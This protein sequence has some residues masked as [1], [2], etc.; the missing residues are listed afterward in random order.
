M[1]ICCSSYL[2]DC[3]QYITFV[4]R[5]IGLLLI[6]SMMFFANAHTNISFLYASAS[7]TAQKASSTAQKN[8]TAR[9]QTPLDHV[10]LDLLN[11]TIQ[12]NSAVFVHAI[13]TAIIPFYYL[14]NH[15]PVN[16]N[17]I[18]CVKVSRPGGDSYDS[19]LYLIDDSRLD[20]YGAVYLSHYPDPPWLG[21]VWISFIPY[22][23]NWTRR[24]DITSYYFRFWSYG[25]LKNYSYTLI[26]DDYGSPDDHRAIAGYHITVKG[27]LTIKGPVE[28]QAS[29]NITTNLN[30]TVNI[31]GAIWSDFVALENESA[32]FTVPSWADGIYNVEFN[33]THPYV[34]TYFDTAKRVLF[35]FTK[36]ASY[37]SVENSV[38]ECN[39]TTPLYISGM[40]SGEID[41]YG[42]S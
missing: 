38:L 22:Y 11:G 39:E 1:P 12:N 28:L 35:N 16:E 4:K 36:W 34:V 41:D 21:E 10:I 24:Y 13:F 5:W 33:I 17:F 9:S 29:V 32:V 30:Y 8:A 18:L 40:L 25:L 27:Y 42:N 7:S 31:D 20:E 6:V 14:S 2:Y 23:E 15:S 37:I 26:R 3:L 19:A